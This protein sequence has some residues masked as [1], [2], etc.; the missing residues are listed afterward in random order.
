M[1]STWLRVIRIRFLLASIVAVSVGLAITWWQNAHL[2]IFQA[3]VTLAGVL[4]LHARV[5]LLTA[6]CDF[7]RRI[8]LQ[9]HRPKMSGGTGG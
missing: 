2:D 6:S 9:T 7:H 5:D 3:I 8:D 1:L 4:A